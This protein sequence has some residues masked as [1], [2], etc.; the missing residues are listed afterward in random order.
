LILD[1]FT[2]TAQHVAS[3]RGI[4]PLT[5]VNTVKGREQGVMQ[6]SDD[7]GQLYGSRVFP[8]RTRVRRGYYAKGSNNFKIAKRRAETGDWDG[9][10]ELWEMETTNRKGKIAGRAHY[11]MAISS[12]INGDLEGAN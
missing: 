12:E 10:A 3:G 6:L 1:E 8:Y 9:A 4:N 7:R 11:N 2:Q 5:A